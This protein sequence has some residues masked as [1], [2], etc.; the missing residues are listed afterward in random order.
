MTTAFDQPSVRLASTGAMAVPAADRVRV[1]PSGLPAGPRQRALASTVVLLSAALFV[2]AVPFAKTPLAQV[3]AFIPIYES[4]LVMT[5]VITA[6]LL[7]GQFNFSRS[8]G[9]L[10]LAAGYLF[11]ALMAVAHALTFPGL[12]TPTGLLGAGP[13]ST[14]WLYMFWHAGFPVCVIAYAYSRSDAAAAGESR[15]L[16]V[17]STGAGVLVAVSAL[18]MLATAG[19]GLLPEIMQGNSYTPAMSL[20]VSSTWMLSLLALAILWRRSPHTVLDVWLMVVMCTWLFDIAL[21]AVL[22][23]GRFDLG[24][25]AGRIYGLLATSFV[26]VVLLIENGRLYAQIRRLYL[27]REEQNRSLEA[28]VRER[29]EQLLQSEKVATMGSLLAGVAHELNNPLAVVM[30]QTHML[31]EVTTDASVRQRAEKINTAAGRCV[32]VVRNFL[33][34][35]RKRPPERTAVAINDVV[36][37]AI[38]LLAYELRSEGIE[39]RTTLADDL[40]PLSGDAHQLHQVLVNLLT[41]AHHAMRKSERPKHIAIT[42]RAADARRHI[43]L[44]I[45]DTGPGIPPEIQEKIFEP[46]F[47]TKPAGQGTG[48]GLPLCRNIV[49]QHGGT[50]TMT[51]TPGRGTTFVI[52][53]PA[54][55]TATAATMAAEAEPVRGTAK[56]ILLVDDEMEIASVLAE[57][58]QRE[59]HTT[60]IAPNGQ[61]ALEMLAHRPY[62]LIIT[63]TKMPLLDGMGLYLEIER[64][65]ARLRG[66]VIFVTGDALDEEKQSFL[67]TTKAT[68]ISKPFDLSDVRAT[69]RRRL[70]ELEHTEP[71]PG[72]EAR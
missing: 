3:W 66:R 72:A 19:Q 69:L 60:Q 21:A 57:M 54:S 23:G 35:A 18:T 32:R 17:V 43:R 48:L 59:G 5:D 13:Q 29:T 58:L 31:M 53:L 52:E 40:P 20:V 61:A 39:V 68:I 15:G 33:A 28:T 37:D 7:F 65:F 55:G 10:L 46:F 38:E 49:G 1:F 4:A 36:K 30:G 64:R 25:Y 9:V 22:N 2:A 16:A 63:D 41:N 27:E 62:D 14:A 44:E 34:L 42:T 51:S 11:T 47:T 56:A 24:F 45:A 67:A 8:R 12:F 50:L 71:A 6:V 26:L 70:A